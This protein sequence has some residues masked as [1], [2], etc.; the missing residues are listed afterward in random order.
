MNKTIV[1]AVT[2]VV[3]FAS[4]FIAGYLIAKA[5]VEE[6]ERR[7]Y[8]EVFKKELQK[9]KALYKIDEELPSRPDSTLEEPPKIK[10]ER[11]NYAKL[12]SEYGEYE[13]VEEKP[14][15]KPKPSPYPRTYAEREARL[16]EMKANRQAPQKEDLTLTWS[17]EI[18]EEEFFDNALDYTQEFWTFYEADE[19]MAG[20]N[21]LPVKNWQNY[22]DMALIEAGSMSSET[23]VMHIRNE[24]SEIDYEITFDSRKF[25]A[26]VAEE[27]FEETDK[28]KPLKFRREDE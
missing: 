2:G 18:S 16:A 13:E 22:V 8:D 24:D 4:G 12:A 23:T 3:G 17:F 28:A 27:D 14:G 15:S 10:R 26:V 25:S 7:H 9:T 5:R 19:V 1:A 20:A 21:D 11:V 6:I